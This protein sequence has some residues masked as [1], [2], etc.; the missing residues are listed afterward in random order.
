MIGRNVPND[1]DLSYFLHRETDGVVISFNLARGVNSIGACDAN[2]IILQDRVISER[3]ALIL[4]NREGILVKDLG[5]LHGTFVNQIRVQAAPVRLGDQ[6]RFGQITFELRELAKTNGHV[7]YGKS[8]AQS[9]L[10]NDRAFP[11][12]AFPPGYVIGRSSLIQSLYRE[13]EPLLCCDLPVLI[14]GETGVGKEY[15]AR[16]LHDSSE[17]RNGPFIA[18]NCAAIPPELLEAEM[19]GIAK[20]VATGVSE[21]MGKFE[22]ANGGSL[23]LDEIGEMSSNAQAKLLR[24]LQEKEIHPLGRKPVPIDARIVAATNADIERSINEGRFRRDLFY[25]VAGYVLNVPPVRSRK[26]DIPLIVEH[27]VRVYSRALSKS[28]GEITGKAMELLTSYP[29]PGNIREMQHEMRRL[30]LVCKEGHPINVELLMQRI[31]EPAWFRPDT[32]E[33]PDTCSLNL[34]EHLM[35]AEREILQAAFTHARG[36][37]SEAARLLGIS[38]NGLAMKMKRL[39]IEG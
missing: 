7:G 8:V 24:A 6:V 16:I 3:H 13:M 38:R 5:S 10:E 19:F 25:R 32:F 20:G 27:M 22:M 26:E 14:T 15:I 28:V 11:G 29:W 33:R 17:R 23:F 1:D 12:F 18:L 4:C 9:A 39:G 34:K 30:V 21:R 37:Q 35:K 2:D 36:N 31:R